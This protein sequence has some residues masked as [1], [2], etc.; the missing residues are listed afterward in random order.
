MRYLVELR[1]GAARVLRKLPPIDRS[2]IARRIDALTLTPRPA[3]AKML[4]GPERFY[5][6]R[7]GDYRVIY[8]VSDEV[9]RLLVLRIGHRREIY[10]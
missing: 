2:R 1:P 8:Q 7:V 4:S 3:G 10:R 6:I 9:L 5:R